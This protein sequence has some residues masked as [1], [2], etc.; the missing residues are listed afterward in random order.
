M[1]PLP[2]I[3]G[4]DGGDC[5]ECTCVSTESYECGAGHHD[6][7]S[8]IDPSAECVDVDDGPTNPEDEDYPDSPM[9]HGQSYSHSMNSLGCI[10]GYIS[11]GYCDEVNNNDNCGTSRVCHLA[12]YSLPV[13][14]FVASLVS[15]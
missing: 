9:T 8:C 4:Y 2:N 3:S 6:G 11:D 10:P 14:S 15:Q 5:C 13:Y 12:F 7:Y 1:L